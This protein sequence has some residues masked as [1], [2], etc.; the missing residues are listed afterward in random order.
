MLK[1]NQKRERKELT[2][3]AMDK[4]N[5]RHSCLK[6]HVDD[7][8]SAPE[9]L[10]SLK[11]LAK[12]Y[13]DKGVNIVLLCGKKP[14]V[15][16]K[17]WQTRKQIIKEFESMPWIRSDSF[18]VLC[19]VST[20]NGVFLAVV[21]FDVKNLPSEIVQLGRKVLKH[22]PITQLEETPSGG[23]H[24]IYLCREKPKT[25]NVYHNKAALELL[26]ENKI[27][28][29]A[30][31]KGY[32]RLNDN[33]PTIVQNIEKLFYQALQKVGLKVRET[34][35]HTWFSRE[36]LPDKPYHGREPPCIK[37]LMRGVNQGLRS[38]TGIRISAYLLNFK[39]LNPKKALVVFNQWNQRNKPPLDMQE[40]H[41][42]FGS[43]LKNNYCFGCEDPLLNEFCN[44]QVCVIWRRRLRRFKKQ[45]VAL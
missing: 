21:D 3:S 8:G 12:Q 30:P 38:E 31:S 4:T 25:I 18:G 7:L 40:L 14:L 23:M 24:W 35:P 11:S 29:M 17:Q 32:K 13:F 34:S 2:R 33:T 26:G 19:G 42:I 1:D 5:V 6:A 9:H 15:E 22:L 28:I 16:W 10:N 27:C 43:A 37:A 45:V 39:R 20:N 44:E 36:N 41:S